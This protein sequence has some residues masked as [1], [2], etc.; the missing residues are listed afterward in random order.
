VSNA[1]GVNFTLSVRSLS[2]LRDAGTGGAAL[3]AYWVKPTW[4]G[5]HGIV[6][7][8]IHDIHIGR[9]TPDSG[10]YWDHGIQLINATTAKIDTF[11]IQGPSWGNG[12]SAIQ[13]RGTDQNGKS[14]GTQIRDGSITRWVRGIEVLHEAE[15]LHVQNVNISE[16]SWGI[17]FYV[18][19][20]GTVI[21]NNNIQARLRGIQLYDNHYAGMAIS[22][23]LIRRFGEEYFVGIEIY[24]TPVAAGQFQREGNGARLI[25]NSIVSPTTGTLPNGIILGG[26]V[27]D[28]MVMGNT[29]ENMYVGIWL[30][31]A[32][33]QR[34]TVIGN[35]NKTA[36]NHVVDWGT[37]NHVSH[38]IF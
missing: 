18:C 36:M 10:A 25:G 24:D 37:S 27:R 26:F 14:I 21:A 23:N 1:A 16:A 11:N 12:I 3:S 13:I 32:S 20:P 5:L 34:A 17:N 6:T 8:R 19:G 30:S 22:N 31:A 29:T 28:T 35:H 15:G 38:N 7:A 2:L 4:H 9:P 33:V